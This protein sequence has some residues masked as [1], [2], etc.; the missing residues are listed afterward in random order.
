MPLPPRN[1][2]QAGLGSAPVRRPELE[3]PIGGAPP[4]YRPQAAMQPKVKAP[5]GAPPVYCPVRTGVTAPPVYRPQAAVQGKLNVARGAPPVYRPVLQGVTAP[6][7]YRPQAT[8]QGK[9]KAPGGAPPV[10]RP[11]LKGATAPPVYRPQAGNRPG[12]VTQQTPASGTIQPKVGFEF[13]TAWELANT[14]KG[15]GV[16]NTGNEIDLP[17]KV[18]L[19]G[20]DG[21][22]VHADFN[23]T[24]VAEF[25]TDPVEESDGFELM[26][27]MSSLESFTDKIVKAPGVAGRGGNWVKLRAD[28]TAETWIKK[29]DA[30]MKAAPQMTTGVRLDRMI[31]LM[32]AMSKGRNLAGPQ[33]LLNKPKGEG[34]EKIARL[35]RE[36]TKRAEEYFNGLA[37]EEKTKPGM[38][39][40]AGA[41]ALLG[42]YALLG[43]EHVDL[44]Y[45]KELSPLM[46]RTNLG[47]LPANIRS[48][49]KGGKGFGQGIM[50]VAGIPEG[51]IDQK[52]FRR[53]FKGETD[54]S[55]PTFR[56]WIVGIKSG[57]DPLRA[58]SGGQM[59]NLDRLEGVGKTTLNFD[60]FEE[61][62]EAQGLIVELRGM[63]EGLPHNKWHTLAYHL[64]EYMAKLNQSTDE[65]TYASSGAYPSAP[66]LAPVGV[67]RTVNVGG[68]Q[69][70]LKPVVTKVKENYY[71]DPV[72][73]VV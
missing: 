39:Q 38:D 2:R 63:Q 11:A 71:G 66:V 41:I 26:M 54:P 4:V 57:D 36:A 12:T 7:V 20:K 17:V 58:F 48:Y 34:A 53:A 15:T 51:E 45:A 13:E 21:W 64:R 5:G 40:F 73:R 42:L 35:M 18:K 1:V 50:H 3:R 47:K 37:T 6:P 43:K 69:V 10:Y 68:G 67:A 25:V 72:G 14:T 30:E 23:G 52:L 55:G 29:G 70:T 27:Q 60:T 9:L 56:E 33:E 8:V 28:D 49:Y 19:F 65:G 22:S 44:E 24:K 46:A 32:K 31:P 62:H 16:P 59:S 61:E